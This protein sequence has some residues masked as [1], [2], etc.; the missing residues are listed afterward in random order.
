MTS[1][2]AHDEVVISPKG[3]TFFEAVNEIW[4]YRNLLYYFSARAIFS[5][6][7]GTVLGWFWL[8]IRP[9]V[10]ILCSGIVLGQVTKIDSGGVPYV[11][12]LFTTMSIWSF[13]SEA[14]LFVTRSLRVN[15]RLLT[16]LYFPRVIIPVSYIV[17]AFI[18]F[19]IT[20]GF[21]F[22][23]ALLVYKKSIFCRWEVVLV[24]YYIFLASLLALGVGFFTAVFNAKAKD[25]R[26]TLPF[27][28]QMWF[29]MTPVIYPLTSINPKWQWLA[30]INPMTA[31][32]EGF[33]WCFWGGEHA[34]WL[35]LLY[36][37]GVVLTVFLLGVCFFLANEEKFIDCL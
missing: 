14:L 6:F 33:K 26:F 4:S 10:P 23:M 30:K 1:M 20:I 17:P 32:V 25:V 37:T 11:L 36:S 28:L 5:R 18:D 34:G 19:M 22:I 21:L 9:I 35:A 16:K 27:A 2:T 15:R 13:F 31:I 8:V 29:L 24:F 7:S 12:F 3:M